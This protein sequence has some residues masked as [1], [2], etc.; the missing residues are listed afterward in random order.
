MLAPHLGKGFSTEDS[1]G[2]GLQVMETS[3][4]STKDI[5]VFVRLAGHVRE[6][7][8]RSVKKIPPQNLKM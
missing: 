2:S 7:T 8:T 1:D 5:C 4:K 3:L 6:C